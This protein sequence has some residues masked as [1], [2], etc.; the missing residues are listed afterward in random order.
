MEQKLTTQ[1][2]LDLMS[3]IR[4]YTALHGYKAIAVR[5]TPEGYYISIR[6][7]ASSEALKHFTQ[8]LHGGT[9][10]R[11]SKKDVDNRDIVGDYCFINV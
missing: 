6:G 2:G 4:H 10:L 3:Q 8:V 5:E 1:Q 9:V 7:R 11:L